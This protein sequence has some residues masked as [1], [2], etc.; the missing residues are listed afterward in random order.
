MITSSFPP[1]SDVGGLRPAMFAKY[2]PGFGWKP[3]VLTGA[4]PIDDP[5]YHSG[6]LLA[7]LSGSTRV[8]ESIWGL[9]DQANYIKGRGIFSKVESFFRPDYRQPPGFIDSMIKTFDENLSQEKFHVIYATS[10]D[11]SCLT[12]GSFLSKRI[13]VPW[14]ADFRDIVEQ[15]LMKGLRQNIYL[16]RIVYRRKSILET[17]SKVITVSKHHAKVLENSLNRHVDVVYN[18]YDP[19]VFHYSP[20]STS[21]KFKI[22]YMGRILNEWTRNPNVL[23]EGLDRLLHNKLIDE[24]L[25]E[26]NFFGT[27][28]DLVD[29][30]SQKYYC[31][32]FIKVLPRVG[33]DKV[34]EILRDSNVNIVLNNKGRDGI[35]TTKLFEYMAIGKPFICTPSGCDELKQ[36]VD[37]SKTGLICEKPE[38][39]YFFIKE[40]YDK[41][42]KSDND[43]IEAS[44]DTK[45]FS[46]KYQTGIF[47]GILNEVVDRQISS[48]C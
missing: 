8:V 1:Q 25:F 37:I 47:A 42:R 27:E 35:L 12:V 17:S 2:L 39:I 9:N 32:K 18:G 14:V 45:I 10:P 5:Q 13:I 26:I 4:Y 28:K 11:F 7:G 29:K 31:K 33:Y 43:L 48:V 15:D 44:D 36:I 20:P 3:T 22:T 6:M 30:L 34:P 24:K 23:F 41:W 46:R 21:N 19:E 16:K 40:I 38:D